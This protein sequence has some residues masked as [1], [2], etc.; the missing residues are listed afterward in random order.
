MITSCSIDLLC[1]VCKNK[2]DAGPTVTGCLFCPTRALHVLQAAKASGGLN[3]LRSHD[4]GQLGRIQRDL[5]EK[6][7]QTDTFLFPVDFIFFIE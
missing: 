1:Q 6:T 2:L 7:S 3:G 4:R 5:N